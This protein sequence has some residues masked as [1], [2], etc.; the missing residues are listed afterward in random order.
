M[1]EVKWLKL[2]LLSPCFFACAEK[3]VQHHYH[4]ATV[5]NDLFQ[6]EQGMPMREVKKSQDFFFKRCEVKDRHPYFSH[7]EYDC[8]VGP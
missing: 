6:V 8:T 7:T 2:F 3:E 5:V 1:K 4:P